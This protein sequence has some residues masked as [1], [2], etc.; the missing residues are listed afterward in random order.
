MHAIR[1][2]FVIAAGG[3]SAVRCIMDGWALTW[4]LCLIGQYCRDLIVAAV[5]GA[6]LLPC[7]VNSIAPAR[8]ETSD[9]ESGDMKAETAI[10]GRLVHPTA[11]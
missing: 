5:P 6:A 9:I 3:W 8:R 10:V 11:L 4:P 7:Q 2:P 1:I